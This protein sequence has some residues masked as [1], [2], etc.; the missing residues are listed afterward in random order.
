MVNEEMCPVA[1]IPKACGVSVPSTESGRGPAGKVQLE[2]PKMFPL[3]FP[4]PAHSSGLGKQAQGP[5]AGCSAP[6]SVVQ[7][8]SLAPQPPPGRKRESENAG[9][10]PWQY[11]RARVKYFGDDQTPF[12]PSAFPPAACSADPCSVGSYVGHKA[13]GRNRWARMR[14]QCPGMRPCQ[15]GPGDLG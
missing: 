15:E 9:C 3:P 2:S 8:P 10:P 11:S 4:A 5:C 1:S 7:P 6:S 13:S 12:S 14:L